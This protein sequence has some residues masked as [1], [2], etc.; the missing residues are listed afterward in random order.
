VMTRPVVDPE[1]TREVSLV[2]ISGRRFS[3]AVAAFITAIRGYPWPR[4]PDSP[5]QGR[6]F[7]ESTA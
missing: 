6:I 3:P 7:A 5:V 1:V 2:A 4:S